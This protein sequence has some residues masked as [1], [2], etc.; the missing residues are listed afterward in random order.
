MALQTETL[1]TAFLIRHSTQDPEDVQSGKKGIQMAVGE[2]AGYGGK[3]PMTLPSPSFYE[4]TSKLAS[5]S[6]MIFLRYSCI[7]KDGSDLAQRM[8]G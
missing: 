1:P 3:V 8:G 4:G 5:P 6:G 7:H 2:V